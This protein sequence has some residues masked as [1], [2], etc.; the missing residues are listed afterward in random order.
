MK[1]PTRAAAL[2]ARTHF[3]D[4]TPWE[5]VPVQTRYYS[6]TADQYIK[7]WTLVLGTKS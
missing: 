2:R 5:E 6:L 7:C 4:W 3:A 1:Y